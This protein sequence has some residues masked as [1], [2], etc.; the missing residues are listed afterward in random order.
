MRMRVKNRILPLVVLIAVF[1]LTGCSA[2]PLSGISNPAKVSEIASLR[3][4][5]QLLNL[6]NGLELSTEQMRFIIEKVEEANQI[7]EEMKSEAEEKAGE[8]VEAL[9]ELKSTLMQGESISPQIRKGVYE[10]QGKERRFVKEYEKRIA[11][12]AAEIEGILE[13]HQIYALERFVPCIIPPQGGPLIGQAEGSTHTEEH[14]ARLREMPSW[15]FEREKD[16]IAQKAIEYLKRHLPKGSIVILDE[17]EEK[18]RIISL[19]EEARDMSDVEFELEKA[20]LVEELESKYEIP[21]PHVDV[22]AKIARFLL[23]PKIIPLLEEKIA[24]EGEK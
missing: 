9:D 8:I 1:L 23:D 24:L 12:L 19:L 11:K 18:R 4:E 3:R 16:R 13:G 15:K 14:L 2:N 6:I 22:R 10:A 20:R 7:R 17:E 5:I 21:R